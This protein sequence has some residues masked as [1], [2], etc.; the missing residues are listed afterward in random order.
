MNAL[1]Y[2]RLVEF[3]AMQASP[4][5]YYTFYSKVEEWIFLSSF[6][7]FDFGIFYLMGYFHGSPYTTFVWE[8]LCFLIKNILIGVFFPR[9]FLKITFWLPESEKLLGVGHPVTNLR[10]SNTVIGGG[11]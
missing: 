3:N 6:I 1:D 9:I 11:P 4:Q 10:H 2:S 5:F 7:R 8:M